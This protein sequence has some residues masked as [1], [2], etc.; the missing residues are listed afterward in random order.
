MGW[1]MG[2]NIGREGNAWG[3]LMGLMCPW[4]LVSLFFYDFESL[5]K[6]SAEFFY[7]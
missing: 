4:T 2:M 1:G 5:E 3:R 7:F 6:I